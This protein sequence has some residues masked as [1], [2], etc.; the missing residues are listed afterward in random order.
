MLNYHVRLTIFLY[1]SD[2]VIHKKKADLQKMKVN[3]HHKNK[4]GLCG[5]K[6]SSYWERMKAT[7]L[8]VGGRLIV[9]ISE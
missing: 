4:K 9:V 8:V 6:Y 5:Q 1:D 3:K 2:Y 7:S